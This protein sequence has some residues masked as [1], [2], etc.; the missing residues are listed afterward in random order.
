MITGVGSVAVLVHDAKKSAA[1]YRDRLG[2][3][4]VGI[5]GHTVFVKPKGSQAL[6]LHLC[7]RCDSWE[8]D[9]PGGRTGIW[10]QCGEITIRKDTGTGRVVPASNSDNVERTYF[11]LKKNGVEFSEE[12]TTTNWG[13]Y[14][15]L[16]DPDGNEFEIS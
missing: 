4:I 6:L 10:L 2:F 7:E 11:E 1:W 5:E 14:A 9:Q 12:L 8:Q 16:K 3:E 13:K 15:I